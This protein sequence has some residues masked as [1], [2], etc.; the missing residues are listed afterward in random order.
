MKQILWERGLWKEGMLGSIDDDDEH[1]QSLNMTRVL[2][3][4]E[5]FRNETTLL[6]E[7]P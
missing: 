6:E 3:E 2:S 4:C 5:D 1:N 7:V